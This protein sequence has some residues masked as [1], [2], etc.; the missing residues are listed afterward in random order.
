MKFER[1]HC[2]W[3]QQMQ[4]QH[5]QVSRGLDVLFVRRCVSANVR[6]EFVSVRVST[7]HIPYCVETAARTKLDFGIH[8][9]LDLYFKELIDITKNNGT[10]L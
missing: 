3:G 1:S 4:L 2:Q 7:L 8:A 9:S 5:Q 6:D 10:S